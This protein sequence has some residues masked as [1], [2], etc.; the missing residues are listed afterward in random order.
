MFTRRAVATAGAGALLTASTALCGMATAATAPYPGDDC[1]TRCVLDLELNGVPSPQNS[2]TVPDTS[3][4]G[5]DGRLGP[6]STAHLGFN[7]SSVFFDRHVP[8]NGFFIPDGNHLITVPDAADGSLDPGTGN[9]SVIIRYRTKEKFGN[10]IQKGQA[11]TAGGQVKFQQPKGKMTCMFKTPTGTATAGSGTTPL[12]D[13]L[14]H[15][16]RC[17]RTPT[18][19]TM[20]VDGVR[21]GRVNHTTGNLDNKKPWSIGGKLDCDTVAGSGADSCDYFSGDIDYVRIIKG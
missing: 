13:N 4:M 17:D 8:T 11:T 7:G 18:S 15:T 12:N 14:F 5:H 9:F 19:V 16:V 10:V 21:T 1:S 6:D 3:G 2:G 20:W